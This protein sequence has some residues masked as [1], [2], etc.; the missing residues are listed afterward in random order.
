MTATVHQVRVHIPNYRESDFERVL[1]RDST[2]LIKHHQLTRARRAPRSLP[3]VTNLNL[4]NKYFDQLAARVLFEATDRVQK[5]MM[6]DS[7]LGIVRAFKLMHNNALPNL[8][9]VSFARSPITADKFGHFLRV[10]PNVESIN[11]H[12]CTEAVHHFTRL[13]K[14]SL[15][16]L[17]H[18]DLRDTDV[19]Y[20]QLKALLKAAPNMDKVKLDR[21][22][23][24]IKTKLT[25]ENLEALKANFPNVNFKIEEDLSFSDLT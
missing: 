10:A 16:R 1:G 25:E 21:F 11:L 5:I 3:T 12:S 13:K 17:T 2:Y 18:S 23:H 19:S 9:E 22:G 4:S 20:K 15:P 6:Q 7:N 14:A 8:T 24:G